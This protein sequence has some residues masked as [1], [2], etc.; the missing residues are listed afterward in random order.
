MRAR[1]LRLPA[2]AILAALAATLALAACGGS[3]ESST[4]GDAPRVPPASFAD[5]VKG[6]EQ[7]PALA[8]QKYVTAINEGDGATI[9]KL[10]SSNEKE[11][12][13]CV[14]TLGSSF[15]AKAQTVYELKSVTLH[16]PNDATVLLHQVKPPLK[17]NGPQTS[18]FEMEEI[19][20]QWQV[21][22]VTAR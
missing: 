22:V 2:L 14:S 21:N 5:D 8:V 18:V 6:D 17:P 4:E 3:S 15:D 12:K 7:G 20:G 11:L 1:R 19:D 13:S 10:T 16:P 9:C